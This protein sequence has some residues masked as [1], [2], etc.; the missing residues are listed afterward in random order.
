MRSEVKAFQPGARIC[1]PAKAMQIRVME[2]WVNT[3]ARLFCVLAALALIENSK[4]QFANSNLMAATAA[5]R[6]LLSATNAA[7]PASTPFAPAATVTNAASSN[8]P[9][10]SIRDDMNDTHLI[11][12]GDKLSFRIDEDREDPR[13]LPVTDSGEIELPYNLGRF[14]ATDK[15][16]RKLAQ[17]IKTAVEKD[18]YHHATVHLGIDTVNAVRGKVY[19][20]GQVTKPGP[21]TV[22]SDSVLKLSQALLLAGPPTQW[23]KLSAVRVVRGVGKAAKTFVINA[24][25]FNKGSMENDIAL[26][27]EDWIIVP[28]RGLVF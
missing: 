8:V 15:T 12:P 5:V 6:H 22:P 9:A 2:G 11:R 1:F 28:E 27:P 25:E 7:S 23:A 10:I 17:E 13:L 20:Q 21:V 16:C 4:A 26:E 14:K 18:F 19:V 24:E 3:T